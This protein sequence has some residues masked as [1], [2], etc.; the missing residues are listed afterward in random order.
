MVS[1]SDEI[2]VN[3]NLSLVASVQSVKS[4]GKGIAR[5]FSGRV[6]L[7]GGMA[8]QAADWLKWLSLPPRWNGT[9]DWLD[10]MSPGGG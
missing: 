7:P 2:Y 10:V 6:C 9:A 8:V 4:A 5:P 1:R 3:W